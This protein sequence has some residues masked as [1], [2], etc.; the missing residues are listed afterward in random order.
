MTGDT[1]TKNTWIGD[2]GASCHMTNLADV[3]FETTDIND[4]YDMVGHVSQAVLRKRAKHYG[5]KLLGTLK[6]YEDYS[7]AKAKSQ[8]TS[9]DIGPKSN[10][11][12]DRI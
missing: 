3:I 6:I 7:L 12:G 10:I 8:N 11:P 4:F 2:T 5:C 1:F 9:K